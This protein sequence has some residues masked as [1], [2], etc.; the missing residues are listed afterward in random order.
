MALIT[1]VAK[2]G[3]V[4]FLRESEAESSKSGTRAP[5]KA[6]LFSQFTKALDLVEH[7]LTENGYKFMRLDGSMSL[8]QRAEAVRAFGKDPSVSFPTIYF[9]LWLFLLDFGCILLGTHII[10]SL[11][12]C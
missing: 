3:S 2:R 10:P 5:T 4:R 8:N 6:I 7:E 11:R 1:T 12:L 9:I